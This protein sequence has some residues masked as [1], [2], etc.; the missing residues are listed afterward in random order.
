MFCV[1]FHESLTQL[2]CHC[3]TR[4]NQ[5]ALLFTYEINL[6]LSSLINQHGCATERTFSLLQQ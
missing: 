5:V 2:N 6:N 1:T 4:I 3:D